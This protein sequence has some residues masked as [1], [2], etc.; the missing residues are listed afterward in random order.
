M[1]LGSGWNGGGDA[2][3]IRLDHSLRE[4]REV[5]VSGS[6]VDPD[7]PA[8]LDG[9]NQAFAEHPVELCAGDA[10]PLANAVDGRIS[11]K[12]VGHLGVPV[13]ARNFHIFPK[14][15]QLNN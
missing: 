8:H 11:R 13:V 4:R 9:F 10:I 15:Q 3:A 14:T 5:G 12:I 7:A 1:F 2:T 6:D